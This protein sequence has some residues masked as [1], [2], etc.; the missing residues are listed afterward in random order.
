MGKERTVLVLGMHR[1]GTS[2]LASVLAGMG[3]RMGDELLAAD[4]GNPRGYFEDRAILSFHK[5]LLASRSKGLQTRADFL[6]GADFNPDWNDGERAEALALVRSLRKDGPWGWKEPRTCLFVQEW[7][8]ILPDAACVAVYRHPLDI[9]HS[10][11]RRGD[12][13]A[14]FAPESVFAAG[15]CITVTSSPLGRQT[16]NAS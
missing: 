1:S 2:Y 3:V 5:R 9:F 6:P 4:R 11:L 14:L 8:R 10:F 7:L 13:S 16:R 12:W 15:A